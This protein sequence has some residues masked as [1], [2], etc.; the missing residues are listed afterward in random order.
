ML[1]VNFERIGV[2]YI[3]CLMGLSGGHTVDIGNGMGKS[4]QNCGRVEIQH[5][6]SVAGGRGVACSGFKC[7]IEAKCESLFQLFCHI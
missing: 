4:I 7:R 1:E 3:E 2:H 5:W 6:C